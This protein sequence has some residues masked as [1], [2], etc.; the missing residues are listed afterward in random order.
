ML[1]GS[2]K[3]IKDNWKY[4]PIHP[5]KSNTIR[6]GIPIVQL[7]GTYLCICTDAG[8]VWRILLHTHCLQEYLCSFLLGQALASPTLT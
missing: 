3:A 4:V 2:L 8:R 7:E 1:L 6:K 5:G